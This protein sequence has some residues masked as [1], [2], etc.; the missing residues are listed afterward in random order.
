MTV[1]PAATLP[2]LPLSGD[3]GARP[4]AARAPD[5]LDTP[6]TGPSATFEDILDLLDHGAPPAPPRVQTEQPPSVL[7]ADRSGTETLS[8]PPM[9]AP[10]AAL[11]LEQSRPTPPWSEPVPGLMSAPPPVQAEP[12]QTGPVDFRSVPI[13]I[14]EPAVQLSGQHA[15]SAAP[16]LQPTPVDV[17]QAGMPTVVQS[18][19][20]VVVSVGAAVSRAD[21]TTDASQTELASTSIPTG[22]SRKRRQPKADGLDGTASTRIEHRAAGVDRPETSAP[23]RAGLQDTRPDAAHGTGLTL[24]VSSLFERAAIHVR[25]PAVWDVARDY[26]REL[27]ASRLSSLGYAV[28]RIDVAQPQ[29]RP[30]RQTGD[31]R[32]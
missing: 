17:A 20:V 31:S 32:P 28:A 1:L 30:P 12:A 19:P 16:G 7:T 14:P 21:P 25:L 5:G 9:Q 11:A 6:F 2:R 29:I 3:T 26:V 22:Q 27:I 8:P 10:P 13:T 24:S 4:E 18:G 15:A 23:A